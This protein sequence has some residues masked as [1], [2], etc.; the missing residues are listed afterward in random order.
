MLVPAGAVQNI[1]GETVVFVKE[2][3]GFAAERVKTGE[4]D[5]AM[6]EVLAGLKPG[7]EYVTRGAFELKAKIV[8]S[9]MDP[10]AGHGH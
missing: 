7:D 2:S 9:G 5:G 4:S 3:G 1:D 6:V 10:H 8:T